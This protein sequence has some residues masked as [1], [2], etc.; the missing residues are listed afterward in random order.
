MANVL[1][2]E[3]SE[4][5]DKHSKS[6]EGQLFAM[7]MEKKSIAALLKIVNRNRQAS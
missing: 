1:A 2:Q 3:N 5:P 7:N 4:A 6:E